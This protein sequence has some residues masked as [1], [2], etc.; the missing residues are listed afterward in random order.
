LALA[1]VAIHL[2]FFIQVLRATQQQF[3][4]A[5]DANERVS[6]IV[7]IPLAMPSGA[8]RRSC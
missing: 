6:A 2:L 3:A 4:R 7:G 1:H 8:R 5:E